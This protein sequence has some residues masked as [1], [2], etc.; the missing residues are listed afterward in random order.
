MCGSPNHNHVE[1]AL[2][3]LA[4]VLLYSTC[5]GARVV[6]P[7]IYLGRTL[8]VPTSDGIRS[9]TYYVEIDS[10]NRMCNRNVNKGERGSIVWGGAVRNIRAAL[11]EGAPT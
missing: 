1:P 7:V 2:A 3:V 10:R 11:W 5:S 9:A 8:Q 6:G 4:P